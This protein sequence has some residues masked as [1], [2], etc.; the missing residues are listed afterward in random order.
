M[1]CPHC[2][3]QLNDGAKFCTA[4]G[5][6]TEAP[7]NIPP[8]PP[9]PPASYNYPPPPPPPAG[10]ESFLPPPPPGASYAPPPA[11]GQVQTA[12]WIGEGWDLLK[13]DMATLIIG[14]IIGMVVASAGMGLL[15]GAISA[16][17]YILFAK[18][19]LT[20]RAEIGDVFKGFNYFVPALVASILVGIFTFVGILLCILPGL[21]VAAVYQFVFLFI[22]DRKLDFWP[23]MEASHAVVKTD[24]MGFTLFLLAM[25]CLHIAGA[26]LCGLG[27]I[28]TIPLQ[29]AAITI[30]YRDV[31]GFQSRG[32]F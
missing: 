3:S 22:I 21:V 10:G 2:G 26:L 20:G 14:T 19:L 25:A 27:L 31:V 29:Y 11:S 5:Q 28:V 1:F 15:S 4:C 32:E 18:K 24:Y 7:A 6:P 8:P 16:G 13:G 12:K 9:P 17:T 23:A 30:A